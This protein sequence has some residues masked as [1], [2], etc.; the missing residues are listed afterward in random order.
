LGAIFRHCGS[1]KGRFVEE[2]ACP[3]PAGVAAVGLAKALN[4]GMS[5]PR[6]LR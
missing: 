3:E 6:R 5:Q 1:S 4:A 2:I